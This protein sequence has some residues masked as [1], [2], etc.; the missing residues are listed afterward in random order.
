MRCLFLI[1]VLSLGFFSACETSEPVAPQATV[2][3]EPVSA[4]AADALDLESETAHFDDCLERGGICANLKSGGC[5][6]RGKR[7]GFCPGLAQ[8]CCNF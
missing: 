4:P 3:V 2:D 6:D 5:G 7:E 1:S 8:V